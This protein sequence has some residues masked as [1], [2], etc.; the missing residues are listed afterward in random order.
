MDNSRL[1]EILDL[2]LNEVKS[3]MAAGEWFEE[4]SFRKFRDAANDTGNIGA[5]LL[6][7]ENEF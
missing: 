2:F 3:A 1:Q 5:I 7:Q 4:E 6:D